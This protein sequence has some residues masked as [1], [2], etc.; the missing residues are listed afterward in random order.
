MVDNLILQKVNYNKW[1]FHQ[2]INRN[3]SSGIFLH[4]KL[5]LI[6]QVH[7]CII[8]NMCKV[9]YNKW[10]F[11]QMMNRNHS[12]GIF[13]YSKLSLNIQIHTCIICNMYKVNYNKWLIHQMIN[14]ITLQGFF[15]SQSS[16]S[17]YKFTHAWY[18]ICIIYNM[19]DMWRGTHIDIKV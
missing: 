12:S 18:T 3:H 10:L 11:H 9:Y 7:T 19:Y 4:L 16:L 8:Y 5:T 6:I 15:Y 17:I 14:S 13:L 1:L 2:M